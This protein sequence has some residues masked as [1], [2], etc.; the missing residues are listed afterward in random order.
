[1]TPLNDDESA[2]TC[3][4]CGS[5]RGESVSPEDFKVQLAAGA[6]FNAAQ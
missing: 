5:A 4:S 6:I 2:G 3:S 1:M